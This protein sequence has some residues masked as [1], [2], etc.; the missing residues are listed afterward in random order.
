MLKFMQAVM[1]KPEWRRKMNE[2]EI[3]EKWKVEATEYEIRPQVF[4]YA[5]KELEY[6]AEVGDPELGVEPTGVDLVWVSVIL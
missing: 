1:E 4:N 6:L 2:E 5:L 3:I